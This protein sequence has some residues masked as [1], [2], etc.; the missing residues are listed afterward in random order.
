M[1]T[2]VLIFAGVAGLIAVALFAA[3]MFTGNSLAQ[4]AGEQPE[5][6][7]DQ[8]AVFEEDVVVKE[9]EI[10]G[11]PGASVG[12]P[13]ESA[14]RK[15]VEDGELSHEDVDAVMSD[16]SELTDAVNY[17]SSTTADGSEK[18]VMVDV[19]I[20]SDEQDALR[21][22]MEKALDQAISDGRLTAEQAD[23]VLAE[24]DAAPDAMA[25][26]PEAIIRFEPAGSLDEGDLTAMMQSRLD[27]AVNEGRI[28]Q[29]EA[30][31]FRSVLERLLGE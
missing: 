1:K 19:T 10:E 4:D 24:V 25:V 8:A 16:L 6:E 7:A 9:I 27:E 29:A 14:L 15:M 12:F 13:F 21:E 17:E 18:Q 31:T 3:G 5:T 26:P 20:R 28:R 30:E 2:K 11:G 22:A 23:A